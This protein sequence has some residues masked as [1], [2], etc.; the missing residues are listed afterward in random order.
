[1]IVYQIR[2]PTNATIRSS[3]VSESRRTGRTR[4]WQSVHKLVFSQD[5]SARLEL[6]AE[7]PCINLGISKQLINISFLPCTCPIGLKPIQSDIECKC[8]CDP[9]LQQYQITNC[10]EEN[11]NIK[12]ERNNN[13]WIE[14][15]NTTNGTGY[16]V[17]NCVFDYCVE[18][19][20]NISLSNPDEQCAYNRSGILCGECEPGLSLVLATSNCKEHIA[21]CFNSR[22]QH[23]YS[24]RKYSWA[25]ILR[26]HSSC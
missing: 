12:L 3:V 13:T 10:L 24:N 18:K 23:H 17:S 1:M 16:V 25:H 8:D 11:G 26:Q 2:N 22:A 15:I 5:S 9:D 14:V 21:S 19:P 7:G 6:Y 20:V 4:S